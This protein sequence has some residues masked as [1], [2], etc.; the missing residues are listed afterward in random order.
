MENSLLLGMS[1]PSQVAQGKEI[2]VRL[3]AFS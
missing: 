1:C 2:C 3:E